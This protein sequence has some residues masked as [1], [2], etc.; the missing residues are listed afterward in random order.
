LLP[1]VVAYPIWF[2]SDGKSFLYRVASRS[3]V[4]FYRQAWRDGQLVGK[5]QVA[6]RLPFAFPFYYATG[7]AYDFSRDLSTIVYAPA[8]RRNSSFP[9]RLSATRV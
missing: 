4:T 9:H 6:V 1:G 5:A 7:D 2:A 3:D 8:R